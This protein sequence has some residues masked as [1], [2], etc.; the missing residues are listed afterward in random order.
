MTTPRRPAENGWIEAQN[1]FIGAAWF[2]PRGAHLLPTGVL[3]VPGIAHEERTMS[4]GVVALAESLAEQGLP[5]LLIDLHGSS[6]SS[7]R[8]DADDIGARWRE[9]IATALRHLH[10]AGLARVIVVGVRLG[11][12]LALDALRGP[13]LFGMVA[14]SPIASGRQHARELKVLQGLGGAA[15][16]SADGSVSIGGFDLPAPLMKHIERLDLM[17]LEVPVPKRVLL[18]DGPARLDTRWLDRFASRGAAF[19]TRESSETEAW[20]FSASD[21]PALPL[22]DIEAVTRWCV[23]LHAATPEREAA[24]VVVTRPTLATSITFTHRGQPIRETFMEIGTLPLAAVLSEPADVAPAGATRLLMSTVGPGRTF[25][26]FARDEASRGRRALRFDFAGFGTSQRRADGQGGEL[27]TDTG[28]DDVAEAIDHL[29]RSGHA[30]IVL[31]GFCAGAWSMMQAGPLPG[32]QGAAAINVALYRQRGALPDAHAGEA[33]AG[34]ARWL[35]ALAKL[36]LLKRFAAWLARSSRTK[37]PPVEWL[38][39]LCDAQVDV[40]LAYA[41][42]DPGYE[43]LAK[44]LESGLGAKLRQRRFRL[45][46]YEGLGHLVEGAQPRARMFEDVAAFFVA[47]DRRL[48]AAG[49]EGNGTVVLKHG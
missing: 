36:P 17:R 49:T 24:A 25:I 45:E 15:A 10:A 12:T 31:L 16:G 9:D 41:N 29:R 40:L 13:P 47:I 48:V 34:Q 43:Y 18:L 5:T 22:A 42:L 35:P 11:A 37:R 19:D 46:V 44:Q 30:N 33:N 27:Y 3:I 7:G 32:V 8:L 39:A 4:G 21:E 6:Q 14:W 26:D 1:G 20:L 23:R 2:W 28:R 38:E